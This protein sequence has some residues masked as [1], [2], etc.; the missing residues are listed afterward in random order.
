MKSTISAFVAGAIFGLGLILSEMVNPRRVQG[1]LDILGNWDPTLM[2][3]MAG[4]L[5]VA[6]IGYKF[7]LSRQKPLFELSFSVPTNRTID[8]RLVIGAILFGVGWGL[9]GLCPGPAI[10]SITTFNPNIAIFI[11]AMIIGMKLFETLDK[12]T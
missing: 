5:L 2:F 11:V 9:S 3:V 6:T 8:V 1:F 7:V 12:N 10:V 4:A